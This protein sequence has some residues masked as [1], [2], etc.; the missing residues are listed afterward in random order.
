M[1]LFQQWAGSWRH[2][3]AIEAHAT[4][5][6][7]G[8]AVGEARRFEDAIAETD[9]EGLLGLGVKVFFLYRAGHTVV[10]SKEQPGGD[11]CA[12]YLPSDRDDCLAPEVSLSALRDI[13]RL[14]PELAPLCAPVLAG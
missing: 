10:P 3:R 4:D 11:L 1:M 14:V 8:E 12:V 9:A 13:A 5:A 7:M 6:E 2:C